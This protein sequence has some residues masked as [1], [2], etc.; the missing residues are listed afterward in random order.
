MHTWPI[1]LLLAAAAA[2]GALDNTNAVDAAS[3]PTLREVEPFVARIPVRN[4]YD[5]AVK[6]R[7]LDPTCS[8]A[9]LEMA[10]KFILPKST[11]TLNIAVLNHN[12]SGAM[13]VGV[14]VFLTDPELETIE[15]TARW[16]IR[17]CVQV[18][19]ITTGAD[20]LARPEDPAWRDVYR[21]ISKVRPD[22][23]GRL[24]KRIRL[25]CPEGELP[26]GGLK[27]D[28]IDYAGTLWAFAPVVQANGSILVTASARDPE[29]EFKVGDY[30]EAVILRTNHPDKARIELRFQS[31][32]SRDAGARAVDPQG[33]LV[34]PLP[35]TAK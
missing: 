22:E 19:A 17:A 6:V 7:L 31:A 5:R 15:V 34:P 9:T 24:R 1:I 35:P 14:T 29:A 16:N 2:A 18:D 21:Y 8:C 25:S 4:P 13:S 12:R 30:D 11:T 27:L 33:G 26:A 28:G 10:E 32:V 3:A 23:L 20:P